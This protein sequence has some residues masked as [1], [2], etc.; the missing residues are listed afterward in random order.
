MAIR[1]SHLAAQ[2]KDFG[3]IKQ[4]WKIRIPVFPTL[5]STLVVVDVASVV[6][7]LVE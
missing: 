3:D 4:S 5:V 7:A 2:D 6:L 1:H